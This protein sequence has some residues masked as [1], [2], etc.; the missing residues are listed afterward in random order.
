MSYF[1]QNAAV[2]FVAK[3]LRSYNI[4]LY[5]HKVSSQICRLPTRLVCLECSIYCSSVLYGMQELI[6]PL[7]VINFR[8]LYA[9]ISCLFGMCIYLSHVVCLQL[10]LCKRK[11]R[12]REPGMLECH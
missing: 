12:L 5:S 3:V 6:K 10:L 8:I 9:C 2:S 7:V 4:V 11:Q 1:D